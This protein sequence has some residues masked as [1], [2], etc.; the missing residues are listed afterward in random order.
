MGY[1]YRF[2]HI[3]PGGACAIAQYLR[4]RNRLGESRMY[5][6]RRKPL[7]YVDLHANQVLNG[8]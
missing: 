2:P 7:K 4:R 6:K 3:C 8:S 1:F 5:S